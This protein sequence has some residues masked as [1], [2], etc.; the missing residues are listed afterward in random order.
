[1]EEPDSV[2][3]LTTRWDFVQN[4]LIRTFLATLFCLW[5]FNLNYSPLYLQGYIFAMHL[6]YNITN[7]TKEGYMGEG[8]FVLYQEEIFPI[9]LRVVTLTLLSIAVW[10]MLK[11]ANWTDRWKPSSLSRIFFRYERTV[12]TVWTLNSHAFWLA[13]LLSALRCLQEHMKVWCVLHSWF[14]YY[15]TFFGVAVVHTFH[16]DG[17]KK[18]PKAKEN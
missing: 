18:L 17:R 12:L 14:F 15:V 9:W 4:F 10:I 3:E 6:G 13:N 5:F 8:T 7:D 1:M 2:E 11:W 16:W